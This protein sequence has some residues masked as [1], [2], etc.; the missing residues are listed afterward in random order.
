MSKLDDIH[1][2]SIDPGQNNTGWAAFKK[3]GKLIA[4]DKVTG[5]AD[6]FMD[7]IE[8]LDPAPKQIVFEE[9]KV[10]PG[11]SHAWS[12]APT[13]QIIGMIKR[14]A[15]KAGIPI[16]GQSNQFLKIGLRQIGLYHIYY[17]R[18]KGKEVRIKHVDDEVSAYAHGTYYL[19]KKGV[20]K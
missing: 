17:K 15:K 1:F 9:Y 7:W 3:D 20:I 8:G 19:K 11:I 6:L 12:D 16:A 13:I 5:G 2:L 10:N 4:F 18:E 14:Y